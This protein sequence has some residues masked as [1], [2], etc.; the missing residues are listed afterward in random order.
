MTL[1]SDGILEARSASSE[2]FGFDRTAAISTQSAET[3]ARAAQAFGQDD[4]ITVLT[5]TR[6]VMA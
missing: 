6:L 3:I 1:L 2:L 5:L 4:D